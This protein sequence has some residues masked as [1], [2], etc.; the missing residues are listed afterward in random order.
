MRK[1]VIL[2]CSTLVGCSSPVK[3]ESWS[4]P[5]QNGGEIVIA[6]RDCTVKGKDYSPLRQA[7]S[8]WN[9]GYIEGC[10]FVQDNMVKI[11]WMRSDGGADTR[12]YNFSDFTQKS[13]SQG[14]PRS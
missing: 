13:K 14:R 7:Y 10:W 11:I 8:Y 5:N 1:L 4:M 3:A 12:M 9:G 2:I 6:A